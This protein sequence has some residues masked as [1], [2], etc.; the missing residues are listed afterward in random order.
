M[1]VHRRAQSCRMQ[2][3][4]HMTVVRARSAL[5]GFQQL[6]HNSGHNYTTRMKNYQL[7]SVSVQGKSVQGKSVQGKCS[8]GKCMQGK[9]SQGKC[10]QGKCS[11]SKCGQSLSGVSM[12]GVCPG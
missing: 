4:P 1:C 5:W 12:Y 11:Q 6:R 7:D 8:Q 9:C 3:F 10:S 2:I